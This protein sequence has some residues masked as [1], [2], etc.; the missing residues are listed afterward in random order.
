MTSYDGFFSL[1]GSDYF[2]DGFIRIMFEIDASWSSSFLFMVV[3]LIHIL[4]F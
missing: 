2:D 1:L 3:G 4:G